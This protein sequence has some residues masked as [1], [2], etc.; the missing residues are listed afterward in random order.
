[1]A[2][3]HGVSPGH[4]VWTGFSHGDWGASPTGVLECVFYAGERKVCKK[5]GFSANLW[6]GDMKTWSEE[7]EL[8]ESIWQVGKRVEW[9][10][11]P[12]GWWKKRPPMGEEKIWG[13][14]QEGGKYM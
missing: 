2:H 12:R 8:F 10:N 3:F 6:G 13:D 5:G 9:R 14:N 11:T 7:R 4:R 1:M